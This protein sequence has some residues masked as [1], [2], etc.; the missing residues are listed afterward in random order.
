MIES[1][2]V[3][4]WFVAEAGDS[5]SNC[6]KFTYLCGF[7]IMRSG[8]TMGCIRRSI[9][10]LLRSLLSDAWRH[11]RMNT[12]WQ[13]PPGRRRARWHA[14]ERRRQHLLPWRR[15]SGRR[16]ARRHVHKSRRHPRPLG[17]SW[18]LSPQG[19]EGLAVGIFK[20]FPWLLSLIVFEIQLLYFWVSSDLPQEIERSFL[21]G[22][23]RTVS[24]AQ[25]T[26]SNSSPNF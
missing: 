19:M 25:N 13:R 23:L 17:V 11:D 7:V 8:S 22:D 5:L 20:R 3:G 14:H 16:R 12:P 18:H 4:E 1:G 15:P 24:P 2:V 9:C 21:V 10:D 26:Q 6:S